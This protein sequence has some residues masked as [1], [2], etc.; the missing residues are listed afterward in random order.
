MDIEVTQEIISNIYDFIFL[1]IYYWIYDLNGLRFQVTNS[2]FHQ[3]WL[4][5]P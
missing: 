2:Q 5:Y 1:I 4:L 3:N